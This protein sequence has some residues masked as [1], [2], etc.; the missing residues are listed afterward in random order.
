MRHA[1]QNLRF[2]S[3][4]M[5]LVAMV[6][7]NNTVVLVRT[8]KVTRLIVV[9]TDVTGTNCNRIPS[10]SA[11]CTMMTI[12]QRSRCVVPVLTSAMKINTLM[13]SHV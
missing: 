10:M 9:E 5:V 6:M 13:D 2:V 8:Q 3:F 4:V 7:N 12:S 11:V 1:L